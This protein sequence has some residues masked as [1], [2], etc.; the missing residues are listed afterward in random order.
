MPSTHD[1]IVQLL[2]MAGLGVVLAG[3]CTSLF[4]FV[5]QKWK[6]HPTLRE[7]IAAHPWCKTGRGIRCVHCGSGSIRNWGFANATDSH[8]LFICNNC[9]ATLFRSS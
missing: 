4:S 7:Y 1:I 6:A 5:L 9:G 3:L 8:R 2:F